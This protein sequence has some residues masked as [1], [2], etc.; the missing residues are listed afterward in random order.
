M[1]DLTLIWSLI[2]YSY[3]SHDYLVVESLVFEMKFGHFVLG[4][5]YAHGISPLKH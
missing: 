3:R 5:L 4:W 1:V 2:I